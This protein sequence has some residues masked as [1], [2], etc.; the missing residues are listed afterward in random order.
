MRR[1]QVLAVLPMAALTPALAAD[2]DTPA[3]EIVVTATRIPTPVLDIPAGVTVIDRQT[4]WTATT[5]G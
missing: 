4:I 2:P 3:R 1:F 5:P